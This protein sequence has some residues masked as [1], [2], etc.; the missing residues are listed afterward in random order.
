MMIVNHF[1]DLD[2]L[3]IL[4][5]DTLALE[6]TNAATGTG[7]VGAQADLCLRTWGRVP[8]LILVDFFEFGDVFAAQD[9]LN[10]L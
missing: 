4:I 2:I 7:S 5:P 9:T 8:N 3:S 10:G 1:L 6:T